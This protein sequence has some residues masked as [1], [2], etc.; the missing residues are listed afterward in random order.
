MNQDACLAPASGTTRPPSALDVAIRYLLYPLLAAGTLVYLAIELRGPEGSLGRYFGAYLGTVLV[1]MVLVE[2]AHPLRRAWR[3][4]WRIFLR[5]DLPFLLVGAATLA[6]VNWAAMRVA[7]EHALSHGN[8]LA[9]VPLVPGVIAAIL[10][11]DL[12]W[13]WVHRFSH[14]APGRFGRWLWRVHVAHH[15]P[16]QVYVL[17][18]AISH[19]I[20]LIVVR[21]ILVVPGFLLGFPPDVAFAATVITG[22]QGLVSHFNVDSRVGWLNYVLSGTELHRYHHSASAAESKNYG[23]V[24]SVWDQLFGTFVYRP[25]EAPLALGVEDAA[26]Y[27]ADTRVLSVLAYPL[28][29]ANA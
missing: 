2:A 23:A 25:G 5:R 16:A 3:M 19:P 20:N 11:S 7:T 29:R 10:V 26:R 6:A 24:V 9:G 18:H 12:L 22:L 8:A 21:A 28:V 14:E 1:V 15:L 27:P 4:T 13:Y 17:M